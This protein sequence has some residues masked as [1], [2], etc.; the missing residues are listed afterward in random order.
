MSQPSFD[1]DAAVAGDDVTEATYT[2][3]D[4]IDSINGA[5]RKRFSDGVW[6][7]GEIQGWNGKGPHAYFKLVGDCP[8]G[9]KASL[10]VSLFAPQRNRLR[11]LLER[12]RLRLDDGVTVRVFGRLE[13]YGP[14]GSLGLKMS[15]LD[16][17][18]TLGE[19]AM[20]RNEVVRRLVAAG[21]YDANRGRRLAVAPL[22]VGVVTSVGS[23]AWADFVHELERSGFGFRL[24]VIDVRVQGDRAVPMVTRAVRALGRRDDLDVVVIVR[25]GGAKTELSTFDHEAIATAIA[26]CGVPVFTGLGHEIDRSVADEVAH[27]S[28]KTPTAC[29]AALVEAVARYVGA[30]EELWRAISR[31]AS[32][33]VD[34][35]EQVLAGHEASIGHRTGSAAD[36][37]TERLARQVHRLAGGAERVVARAEAQTE[38]AVAVLGH[39]PRRLDA[40]ERHVAGLE[41]QVRLVDP[42]RTMA[43]GWSITR[44]V[45]GRT[46]RDAAQLRPGDVLVTSFAAGSAR[47]TVDAIDIDIDIAVDTVAAD[48]PPPPEETAP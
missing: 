3:G 25:G 17:R 19:M 47:S 41:V 42:V 37:A 34:Q 32:T 40:E 20:Q 8:D 29:A 15:D 21:L 10:N 48:P 38:R 7:R 31:R 44:T 35:R 14:S 45:D 36:R 11:P 16:P 28:L 9:T 2:V 13:V 22:R 33:V 39:T 43:R 18:F 6:V 46:V 30:T 23:A 5:L 27:S 12:H 24:R 1:F 26:R 4:L